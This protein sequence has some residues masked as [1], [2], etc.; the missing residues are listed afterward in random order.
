MPATPSAP[1]STRVRSVS[2]GAS[3][4][5]WSAVERPAGPPPTITR[6]R[7]L[8]QALVSRQAAHQPGGEGATGEHQCGSDAQQRDQRQHDDRADADDAEDAEHGRRDADD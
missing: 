5:T 7:S 3:A 2:P 6:S 8:T 1:I 4:W